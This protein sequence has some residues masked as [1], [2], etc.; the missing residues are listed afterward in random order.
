MKKRYVVTSLLPSLPTAALR[1]PGSLIQMLTQTRKTR[2]PI[3]EDDLLVQS[4]GQVSP[5][6]AYQFLLLKTIKA[7]ELSKSASS[8]WILN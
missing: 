8:L 7:E 3:W 1:H 4:L 2:A 6:S 5:L